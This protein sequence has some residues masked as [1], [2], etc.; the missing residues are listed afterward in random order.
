[1]IKQKA[2]D[3]HAQMND[4]KKLTIRQRKIM[5][6]GL[7][8]KLPSFMYGPPPIY[9]NPALSIPIPPTAAADIHCYRLL[10]NGGYYNIFTK[11][12]S[13]IGIKYMEMFYLFI[14]F[15]K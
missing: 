14:C 4:G 7:P 11:K 9:N 6:N 1:V 8:S 13:I 5:T 15:F 2:T 10:K 12:T 3:L